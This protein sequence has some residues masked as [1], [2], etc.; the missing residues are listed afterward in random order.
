MSE[1]KVYGPYIGYM[2]KL[3]KPIELKGRVIRYKPVA[4]L[5]K[6]KVGGYKNMSGGSFTL[7][8]YPYFPVHSE[9]RGEIIA[10]K[11]KNKL[12]QY[13]PISEIYNTTKQYSE[14]LSISPGGISIASN[15]S[16]FDEINAAIQEALKEL[17][18]IISVEEEEVDESL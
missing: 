4:K 3:K 7:Y 13:N 6:K 16:N 15:I 9:I 8:F 18:I 1:K 11:L 17:N 5:N 14:K 10:E 2:E 12:E